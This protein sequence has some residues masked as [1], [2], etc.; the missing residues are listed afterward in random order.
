[1]NKEYAIIVENLK[2]NYKTMKSFR[3]KSNVFDITKKRE[4]FTA[5][6]NINLKIEQGQVI[7]IIGRN[8]SGKSTLLKT[9][10]GIFSPDEGNV[11][12][13]NNTVSLLS[14]GLGFKAELSGYENIYLSGLLLGFSKEMIEEKIQEIIEFSEL[15]EFIFKPVRTYSSGMYSKLSF[16]IS[17]LLDTDILLIDEVLSVGDINFKEKSYKKMQEII[18]DKNKTILI[19]SHSLDTI[20]EICN[21]TIWIEKGQLIEFDD[22]GKVIDNYI[23]FMEKKENGK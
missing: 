2:V 12:I 3:I 1:M 22:T 17:V 15:K 19:V 5:L 7:G 18:T 4:T 11:N 20:K 8:G 13:N 14:I 6:Q 10:A 16:S 21:K 9:I 23:K